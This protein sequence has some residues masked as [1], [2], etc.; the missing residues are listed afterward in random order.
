MEEAYSK[1]ERHKRA[2]ISILVRPPL[3]KNAG[4]APQDVDHYDKDVDNLLL[5]L[6]RMMIKMIIGGRWSEFLSLFDSFL[7][8]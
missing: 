8:I 2:L 4:S 7:E 5:W 6:R 1:V 3:S